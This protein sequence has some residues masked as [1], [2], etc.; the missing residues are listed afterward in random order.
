[1][2]NR[3]FSSL[4]ILDLPIFGSL[5]VSATVT[6]ATEEGADADNVTTAHVGR[7][8]ELAAAT[9]NV[10]PLE[11]NEGAPPTQRETGLRARFE[12]GGAVDVLSDADDTLGPSPLASDDKST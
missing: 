8:D 7:L 10:R 2:S 6:G 5:V 11:D 12:F 4:G 9:T 3:P 1:M